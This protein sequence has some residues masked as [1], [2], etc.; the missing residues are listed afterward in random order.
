VIASVPLP[1]YP[2]TP[3][4]RVFGDVYHDHIVLVAHQKTIHL[5]NASL[6][7]PVETS[8]F[9]ADPEEFP[10]EVTTQARLRAEGK[11]DKKWLRDNKW[12][13]GLGWRIA[14]GPGLAIDE[15][16]NA[17]DMGLNGDMIVAVGTKGSMWIWMKDS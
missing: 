4:L 17:V 2:Q 9:P 7:P 1:Y 5:L 14:L 13:R 3:H 12:V 8:E 6:V 16:I 15:H 10:D 11:T